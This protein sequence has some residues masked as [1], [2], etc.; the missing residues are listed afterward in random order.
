MIGSPEASLSLTGSIATIS[1]RVTSANGV[2]LPVYRSPDIS[3]PFIQ[4]SSCTVAA[5]LCIFT[6]DHFSLFAVG[7]P[8][9]PLVIS[10]PLS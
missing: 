6:T 2:T 4:I 8:V 7:S 5:G 10:P 3:V 9:A 1:M